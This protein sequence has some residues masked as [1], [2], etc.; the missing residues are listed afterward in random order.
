[1]FGVEVIKRLELSKAILTYARGLK[2]AQHVIQ[3]LSVIS[4]KQ[5][6]RKKT[7]ALWLKTKYTDSGEELMCY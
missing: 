3:C 6:M 1:M 7:E 4:L 5:K 2:S